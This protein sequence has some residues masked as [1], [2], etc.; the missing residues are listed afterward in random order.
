MTAKTVKNEDKEI[1]VIS[2]DEMT[3]GEI[4][5]F[6][7]IVGFLPTDGDMSNVPVGK[8]MIAL[9]YITARRDDPSVTVDDIRALPVGAIVMADTEVDPA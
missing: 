2:L 8:M 7:D 5:A 4:E 6:E 1:K 9:G 3:Y